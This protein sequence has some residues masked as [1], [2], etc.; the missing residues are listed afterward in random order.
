[1]ASLVEAGKVRYLKL[2]EASAET[3]RRAHKVHPIA[4]LQSEYSLFSR[5]VEG[6][7][8]N[9]CKELGVTFVAYSPLGRGFLSGQIKSI[10]DLA[11]DD[12]RRQAPR[13][14]GDNFQKNLEL[15]KKIEE[16]AAKKG[17][18]ASQLALAWVLAQDDHIIALAGTKR[19]KYLEENAEAAKI[20]LT[21]AE[22]QQIEMVMPRGVAAGPRYAEAA[23]RFVQE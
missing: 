17:C 1:M 16:L 18:T 23:M 6:D 8:L 13:F 5:D 4:A 7:I 19:R 11:A 14:Q 12:Y 9:T 15:V 10:N 3:L 22:L 2:S 21:D 20:V